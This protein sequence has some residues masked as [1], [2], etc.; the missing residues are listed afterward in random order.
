M[1]D[2]QTEKWAM[3][4]RI[5][6]LSIEQKLW[7]VGGGSKYRSQAEYFKLLSDVSI[8]IM[9]RDIPDYHWFRCLPFGHK[10]RL[11]Y[12]LH[13]ADVAL[14]GVSPELHQ[15]A[16]LIVRNEI[17]DFFHHTDFIPFSQYH[18]KTFWTYP[19]IS[20]FGLSNGPYPHEGFG[21]IPGVKKWHEPLPEY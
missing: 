20:R 4:G 9:T 7:V 16:F 12:L 14:N 2:Y 8:N 19:S 1:S 3:E 10:R 18:G 15:T 21:V 5:E 17:P 11:G 6:L 13:L